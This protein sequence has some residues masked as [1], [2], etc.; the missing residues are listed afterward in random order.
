MQYRVYYYDYFDV[1]KDDIDTTIIQSIINNSSY[2]FDRVRKGDTYQK[3]DADITKVKS[4]TNFEI[5]NRNMVEW[6]FDTSRYGKADGFQNDFLEAIKEVSK[7]IANV[8]F[9]YIAESLNYYEPITVITWLINGEETNKQDA[10]QIAYENAQTKG[11]QLDKYVDLEIA[12]YDCDFTAHKSKF[13][14]DSA[15]LTARK[16]PLFENITSKKE[17]KDLIDAINSEVENLQRGSIIKIK[18]IDSSGNIIDNDKVSNKTKCKFVLY[19]EN[20][21]Y[22]GTIFKNNNNGFGYFLNKTTCVVHSTFPISKRIGKAKF[23][24]FSINIILK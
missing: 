15:L 1:T 22:L 11:L 6:F 5:S 14:K 23:T 7:N 2:I 3:I 9:V 18:A 12:P 13:S 17:D 20:D 21:I 4:I 24:E 8:P 19:S 10:F 16:F